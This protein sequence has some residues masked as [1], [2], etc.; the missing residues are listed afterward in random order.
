MNILLNCFPPANTMYPSLSLSILKSFMNDNGIIT[1]VKYWSFL[2]EDFQTR[3]FQNQMEHIVG[4]NNLLPFINYVWVHSEKKMDNCNLKYHILSMNPLWFHSDSNLLEDKMVQYANEFEQI[5]TDE[6]LKMNLDRYKIFGITTKFYQWICG[7][8]IAQKVRELYPE[9]KIVIGGFGTADEALAMM[10]N[11]GYYDYAIWGEGEYP[12]LHLYEALE[13]SSYTDVPN[14]IYRSKNGMSQINQSKKKAYFDLNSNIFPDYSDFFTQNPNNINGITLPFEGSRGCHWRK[15][16]FCYLNDGYSYRTKSN[17]NKIKELKHQIEKYQ[18]RKFN[19]ADNDVIGKDVEK[20]EEFLDE[21]IKLKDVYNNFSIEMVEINTKTINSSIVKKMALG[22][23]NC[24][25][26]G[27]ES[28]SNRLLQKIKKKSSFASN[29]LFIKWANEFSILVKGVNIIQGLLEETADDIFEAA[30]NL[31]YLRFF[32]SKKVVNHNKIS[33]K[34]NKSSPYF[35]YLENNNKLV[36]WN[37]SFISELLPDTFYNQTDKYC[38][39]DYSKT[40]QESTQWM[41]FNKI[42]DHFSNSNYNYQIINNKNIIHY[43]E[44][45]DNVLINELAFDSPLHWTILKSCNHSV[46][47]LEE[48]SLILQSSS[49]NDLLLA[50]HSL[51]CEGLLYHSEDFSELVTPINTDIVL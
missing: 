1:N 28:P 34:I 44:Y 24:V 47:S 4:Y 38:L 17:E 46:I 6:I 51:K 9:I 35:K 31:F 33:L 25:Q 16:R 11:F 19:F 3:F 32:L 48:L 15:C 30:D 50:I 7:G 45:L 5:I 26:I 41:S 12:L 20:Y 22:G 21:L 39:F 10:N 43:R 42:E 40:S 23:I 36:D 2:L 13:F 29:L 27:Y 37:Y 49:L 8:I 18:I 14:L